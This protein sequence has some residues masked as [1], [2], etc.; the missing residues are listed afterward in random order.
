MKKLRLL[1][2]LTSAVMFFTAC[3]D[4]GNWGIDSQALPECVGG[5]RDSQSAKLIQKGSKIV[6]TQ[7]GTS[8]RIWH[9][10]N[11]DKKACVLSG[12]AIV[13]S[14]SEKVINKQKGVMKI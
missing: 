3:S 6:P 10:S 9:Y 2:L 12:S 14:K 4:K 8:L 7:E 1:V 11:G 13:E 5:D